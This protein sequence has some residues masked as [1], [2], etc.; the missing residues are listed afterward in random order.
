MGQLTALLESKG[1]TMP[2]IDS[3]IAATA[4]T[5][6]MILATRN[7]KDFEISGVEIINPWK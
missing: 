6:Q 7:V 1:H 4:L 2:A 5:H 3:L